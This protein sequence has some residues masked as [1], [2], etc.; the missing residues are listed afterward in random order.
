M[1][2]R[3]W[4]VGL[5]VILATGAVDA[6]GGPPEFEA[7]ARRSLETARRM[8]EQNSK[9]PREAV[10][11]IGFLQAL[12]GEL[13]A[14][15]AT[16]RLTPD[17]SGPA[18]P[19]WRALEQTGYRVGLSR[20]GDLLRT[21]GERQRGADRAAL[22]FGLARAEFELELV[23]E[24]LLTTV[25]AA[26]QY[27][28]Y[29]ATLLLDQLAG[30]DVP[31]PE[32]IGQALELARRIPPEQRT[33][34]GRSQ[35]AAVLGR[36]ASL[37]AELGNDQAAL[38]ACEAV[39][40]PDDRQ[41]PLLEL[42]RAQAAAGRF[43]QAIDT[44]AKLSPE[45][46]DRLTGASLPTVGLADIAALQQESG[47]DAGA[48]ETVRRAVDASQR[49]ADAYLRIRSLVHA[50]E[51]WALCG[52]GGKASNL[53]AEALAQQVTGSH[54]QRA[55]VLL[56]AG[57]VLAVADERELAEVY[58]KAGRE[59]A[60]LAKDDAT[61]GLAVSTPAT[62]GQVDDSLAALEL[63]R[64]EPVRK[65]GFRV[66]LAKTLAASGYRSDG[67]AAA[68]DMAREL[69]E[70]R[71]AFVTAICA[72]VAGSP[73]DSNAELL[74]EAIDAVK[75]PFDRQSLKQISDTAVAAGLGQ[76]AVEAYATVLAGGARTATPEAALELPHFLGNVRRAVAERLA[77]G[78]PAGEL[79]AAA[80]QAALTTRDAT[81]RVAAVDT[82]ALALAEG[83][84]LV[85]SARLLQ[86]AATVLPQITL[87]EARVA[88]MANHAAIADACGQPELADASF[89][90]AESLLDSLP[91]VP[92]AALLT[93]AECQAQ[94]QRGGAA[95]FLVRGIMAVRNLD[96]E[97][98]TDLL[99]LARVALCG[100]MYA[101][102]EAILTRIYRPEEQLTAILDVARAVIGE[103]L[104]ALRDMPFYPRP[105]GIELARG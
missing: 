23:T 40:D 73:A 4:G 3:Q 70:D 10:Y 85:S 45:A 5:L 57:R 75:D 104:P 7:L 43:T 2:R 65:R 92:P 102:T 89:I 84:D 8:I 56:A 33:A 55:T 13:D 28:A 49:T 39:V 38:Q 99:A 64:E 77:A 12:L 47:D 88:A 50:A 34:D 63:V 79:S 81:A 87:D 6:Q 72:I 48:A 14:G 93:L 27:P 29:G 71:A 32:L 83:G 69:P 41:E 25:S 105:A 42:L 36:L 54:Q 24:A 17:D 100:G 20:S 31:A 60:A 26:A 95:R 59:V 15:V 37:Q 35:Q 78:Q 9:L 97:G 103:P 19:R 21:A 67:I 22:L 51:A 76:L 58:F 52:Q 16:I 80:E 94:A 91:T 1:V 11:D 74:R 18:G 46:A 98:S 101:D 62:V 61:I 82:I 86:S 53:I 90:A 96:K 30:A 66:L 68:R 44:A